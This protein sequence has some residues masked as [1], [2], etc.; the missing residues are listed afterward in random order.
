MKNF[1]KKEICNISHEEMVG[2]VGNEIYILYLSVGKNG[3]CFKRLTRGLNRRTFDDGTDVF[4]T[5]NSAPIIN[6]REMI[7]TYYAEDAK[8]H[9]LRYA[10]NIKDVFIC[11]SSDEANEIYSSWLNCNEVKQTRKTFIKAQIDKLQKLYKEI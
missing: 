6:S 10:P 8:K 4:D 3:G 9:N 2:M 1:R 7:F 5:C 11:S